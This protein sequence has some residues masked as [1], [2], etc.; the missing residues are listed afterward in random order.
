MNNLYDKI[1]SN[2]EEEFQR[3]LT[4]EVIKYEDW[5]KLY[6]GDENHKI[7]IFHKLLYKDWTKALIN[8]VEQIDKAK[9]NLALSIQDTKEESTVFKYLVLHACIGPFPKLLR[10][11]LDKIDDETLNAQI[12]V[13]DKEGYNALL[14]LMSCKVP[15]NCLHVIERV[16]A[17][18]LESALVTKNVNALNKVFAKQPEEIFQCLV[19]KVSSNF[20]AQHLNYQILKDVAYFQS[21][22]NF[23]KFVS[24]L[25][26]KEG[27]KQE[28]NVEALNKVLDEADFKELYGLVTLCSLAYKEK[29][30]F[31]KDD[32]CQLYFLAVRAEKY[33]MLLKFL[34]KA[35]DFLLGQSK[36]RAF[37]EHEKKFLVSLGAVFLGKKT[38][39]SPDYYLAKKYILPFRTDISYLSSQGILQ[40]DLHKLE[41]SVQKIIHYLLN[42]GKEANSKTVN[43]KINHFCNLILA[44]LDCNDDDKYSEKLIESVSERNNRVNP[45]K[46]TQFMQHLINYCADRNKLSG[47]EQILQITALGENSHNINNNNSYD[48]YHASSSSSGN[49]FVQNQQQSYKTLLRNEL[50]QQIQDA[51]SQLKDNNEYAAEVI[52]AKLSG[53]PLYSALTGM[54]QYAFDKKAQHTVASLTIDTNK[55]TTIVPKVLQ[56]ATIVP[57]VLQNKI[58]KVVQ[59]KIPLDGY[60]A[61]VSNIGNFL[62]QLLAYLRDNSDFS[63]E[64]LIK[65]L[66][67]YRAQFVN[68]SKG[69][70][71][72]CISVVQAAINNY[73]DD[74]NPQNLIQ[75]IDDF[76]AMLARLEKTSEP[77]QKI[78]CYKVQADKLINSQVTEL[79]LSYTQ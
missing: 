24:K 4:P 57:K 2:T 40:A 77:A 79:P 14:N 5:S 1:K 58:A 6:K 70:Y 47:N 68:I 72:N 53:K 52:K 17:P 11:L 8:I 35:A 44:L 31:S 76:V 22:E 28:F 41:N 29:E 62:S 71:L 64:N 15:E 65:W 55:L 32:W 74:V 78:L 59:S 43:N 36:G 60:Q 21:L 42:K 33:Q 30:I 49:D 25:L 23:S 18:I 34:V 16:N 73:S 54:L 66:E 38:L 13:V 39:V 9:L 56:T 63:R 3:Y 67:N 20:F 69:G 19:N 27:D 48:T 26:C 37:S 61:A 12:P 75:E 7:T 46:Y 51:M 45:G 10:I 50:Q